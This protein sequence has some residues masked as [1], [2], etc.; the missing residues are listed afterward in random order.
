LEREATAPRSPL[1]APSYP[2]SLPPS[3]N[4]SRGCL[5]PGIKPTLSTHV[6]P[7][8][9]SRSV[10]QELAPKMAWDRTLT[11]AWW[12][13][14]HP[15]RDRCLGRG[16]NWCAHYLSASFPCQGQALAQWHQQ[17][18]CRP[19]DGMSGDSDYTRPSPGLARAPKSQCAQYRSRAGL[20]QPRSGYPVGRLLFGVALEARSLTWPVILGR[21]GLTTLVRGKEMKK[22]R[23]YNVFW[24][25]FQCGSST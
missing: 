2:P 21:P 3:R 15:R 7:P 13:N 25:S 9:L 10:G 23:I 14:A 5:L 6:V 4:G 12:V 18:G 19:L 11:G 17:R 22:H 8:K 1:G 16:V 20:K 24:V